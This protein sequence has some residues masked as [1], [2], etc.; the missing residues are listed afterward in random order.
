MV[1]NTHTND[2]PYRGW[3]ESPADPV[4]LDYSGL[5]LQSLML[6]TGFTTKRFLK[7]QWFTLPAGDSCHP[8]DGYSV[9]V[10]DLMGGR[11]FKPT[12]TQLINHHP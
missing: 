8:C 9:C 10:G 2:R 1:A 11:T 7:N 12:L 6:L 4:T 3:Q 5:R